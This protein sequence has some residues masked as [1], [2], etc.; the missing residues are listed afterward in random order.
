[1][2]P[3]YQSIDV[4]LAIEAEAFL[5]YYQGQVKYVVATSRDGRKVRFPAKV[6]Q[7]VLRR[8]GIRGWFRLSYDQAGKFHSIQ[9][10]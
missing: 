9:A 3:A 7:K 2:T 5:A 10:C 8:E 1:M 6:L 4:W